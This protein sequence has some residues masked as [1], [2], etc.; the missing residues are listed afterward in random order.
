MNQQLCN[1]IVY[2]DIRAAI[3]KE[4]EMPEWICIFLKIRVT[5]DS[6]SEV[7]AIYRSKRSKLAIQQKEH[8]H[9]V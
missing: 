9:I 4:K 2:I 7:E 6:K 5:D 1:K 3:A 8:F